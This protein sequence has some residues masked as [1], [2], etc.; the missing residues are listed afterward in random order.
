MLTTD[1]L[2]QRRQPG[3]SGLT[4]MFDWVGMLTRVV[5]TVCMVY[6]PYCTI[7]GHSAEA[8]GL[9]MTGWGLTY[10]D[11]LRQRVRCPECD[12]DLA[13]SSLETHWYIQHR[14]GQG[15]LRANP[16]HPLYVTMMFRF[17]FPWTARD[18]T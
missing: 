14:V 3:Y 4:E 16:P 5:K 1:S 13:A 10:R 15:D 7:G 9:R 2:Y 18:I 12:A 11:R 6:Q 8:Y 17:C